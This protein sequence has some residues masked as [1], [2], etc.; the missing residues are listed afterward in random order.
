LVPNSDLPTVEWFRLSF[1][2][3]HRGQILTGL[4]DV[5]PSHLEIRYAIS[6]TNIHQQDCDHYLFG[7]VTLTLLEHQAKAPGTANADKPC[8]KGRHGEHARTFASGGRKRGGGRS[9]EDSCTKQERRRRLTCVLGKGIFFYLLT[10]D[11]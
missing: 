8:G 10:K 1:F 11:K 4:V 2:F 3:C 5:G 6:I 7:V 9:G